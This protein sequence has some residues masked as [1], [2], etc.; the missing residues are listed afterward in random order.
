MELILKLF[1]VLMILAGISLLI[2]PGIIIGYIENNADHTSLYIIAI[3]VRVVLGILFITSA[4]KSRY[5]GV[6]KALG[7]LFILAGVILF[8]VGQ[9]RFQHF[10]SSLIPEVKPFASLAGVIAILFGGFVIYA[11]L[12]K[13][14]LA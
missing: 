8:L 9:E 7:G 12:R 6:L 10:I 13:K 1:G 14:E 11:F 2:E 4:K 5:P 3:V